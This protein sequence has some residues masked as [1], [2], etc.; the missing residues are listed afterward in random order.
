MI[1]RDKCHSTLVLKND[2]NE[3]DTV[4]NAVQDL[5]KD[6]DLDRRD[7]FQI[8]MVLDELF[9]NIVSYAYQ[10]KKEHEIEVNISIKKK[11]LVVEFVD[12]GIEFNPVEHKEPD[13]CKSLQKRQEGGLGIHFCRKLMA[14]FTYE[15]L[16]GK[17]RVQFKKRIK[18][19]GFLEKL[20]SYRRVHGN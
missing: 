1:C 3:I 9:T 6:C 19:P 20:F 13:I 4:W 16:N 18:K 7:L 5:V 17:N 14:D 2:L 15:R 10:D 8:N 12:D 11:Y